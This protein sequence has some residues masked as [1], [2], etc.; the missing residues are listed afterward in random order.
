MATPPAPTVWLI[1]T[2]DGGKGLADCLPQKIVALRFV[3][4]G[5]AT[6]LD[7][8]A[9]T[10]QFGQDGTAGAPKRTARMLVRFRD[11]VRIGDIV[12]TPRLKERDV[13]FGAVVSG[14]HYRPPTDAGLRHARAVEWWGSIDRDTDLAQ[15]RTQDLNRRAALY[16]LP[17]QRW[18]LQRAEAVR[19]S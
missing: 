15:N 12:V 14:Y 10:R 17:D 8:E 6:D 9:I 4:V 1:R 19:G 16:E 11:D 5:D 7:L 3:K 2:G 13:W 18:W